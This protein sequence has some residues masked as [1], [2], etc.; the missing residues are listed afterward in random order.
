MAVRIKG[1][2]KIIAENKLYV[3]YVQQDY[4]SPYYVCNIVS[5]DKSVIISCPLKTEIPYAI[6]K[7]SQPQWKRYA[8]PFDVP[9]IIT[10]SF[11]SQVILWA[12]QDCD[13][14][15]LEWNGR[16]VPV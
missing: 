14:T 16:N 7:G 2:R 11:V 15:E 13:R 4:D 12:E 6:F 9:E 1:R 8:L 10:P 5:E 3:W